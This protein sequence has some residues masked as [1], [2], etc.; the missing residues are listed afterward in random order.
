MSRLD[1]NIRRLEAQRAC[2]NMVAKRMRDLP[3]PVLELGLGNGRTYDHLRKLL[4]DRKI[5]AF[6]RQVGAHPDCIPDPEHL[7]LGEIRDTLPDALARLPG[8]AALAHSDLGTADAAANGVLAAWLAEALPPL[9]LD[10][11]WVVS[12]RP[13]RDASLRPQPPPPGIAPDRYFVYRHE[14]K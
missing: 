13:L 10:G 4:P 6:D 2:L 8:K 12:D 9:L 7:L 1:S 3:G 14:P 11:A 5:F